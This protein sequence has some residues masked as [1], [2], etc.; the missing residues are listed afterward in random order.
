MITMQNQMESQFAKMQFDMKVQQMEHEHKLKLQEFEFKNRHDSLEKDLKHT[1]D[2]QS[3][4]KQKLEIEFKAQIALAEEK[5]KKTANCPG[6][7]TE[8]FGHWNPL[9][10]PGTPRPG[11]NPD[12]NSS[13]ILSSYNRIATQTPTCGTVFSADG[14]L[15]GIHSWSIRVQNR[16]S[17]CMIGV[18]P[19]SVPRTT[20][21]YSTQGYFVNFNAG[22]AYGPQRT[23][24]NFPVSTGAVVDVILNC[25][26]RTLSYSLNKAAPVVTHTGISINERLFRVE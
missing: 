10:Y 12:G 19:L 8:T 5:T 24:S 23:G 1:K 14:Y 9:L 18:A 7:W 11:W 4:E 15:S 26:A 22:Y 13:H 21:H 17:T 2:I 20:V 25:V 6:W 16:P 3:L